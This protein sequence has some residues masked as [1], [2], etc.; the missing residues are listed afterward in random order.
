LV[1]R[2][3]EKALQQF[4]N[5]L[6]DRE[7]HQV[8][9]LKDD[10]PLVTYRPDPHEVIG[11]AAFPTDGLISLLEGTTSTVAAREAVAVDADG[12][13]SACHVVITREDVVPYAAA[14]LRRMLGGI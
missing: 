1:Y 14:R 10:R 13:L 4:A 3:R 5:G 2:G 6:I 8:Y 12:N 9:V 7:F 11:L